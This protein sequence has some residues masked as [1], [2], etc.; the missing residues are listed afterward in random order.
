MKGT[1]VRL[2]HFMTYC[3]K[4][5]SYLFDGEAG[6]HT[7][8]K[9]KKGVLVFLDFLVVLTSSDCIKLVLNSNVKLA[10]H[11]LKVTCRRVDIFL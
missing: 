5:V 7:P 1:D 6:H 10:Y 9:L 11:L 3:K 4:K 2:Y 8:K